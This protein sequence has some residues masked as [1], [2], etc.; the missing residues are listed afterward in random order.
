M[1]MKD[2]PMTSVDLYISGYYALNIPDV[3]GI[4]AD[5]H[6]EIYWYSNMQGVKVDLYCSKDL[7]W[8]MQDIEYR[9]VDYY[10]CAKYDKVYIAT[11][12]RAIADLVI[13]V[14]Y[15][16]VLRGCTRDW[17]RT[18]KQ[19]EQLYD[20]LKDVQGISWFLKEE[21]TKLYLGVGNYA[22]LSKAKNSIDATVASPVW[23]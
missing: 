16:E 18:S 6:P 14:P 9:Q 12:V 5:W 10:S 23:E 4:P 15:L 21:F 17:L 8:G 22:G 20:M 1:F 7:P 3:D 13:T 2:L 11:H 19:A